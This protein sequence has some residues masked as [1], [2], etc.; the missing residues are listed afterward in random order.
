MRKIF[1]FLVVT[2]DGIGTGVR[3]W[4]LD[5]EFDDFS[6]AQLD[7]ADTLLF[8][9]VTYEGMAAYWPTAAVR[10]DSP[11]IADRLNSYPKLVVS[12]TLDRADWPAAEICPRPRGAGRVEESARKGHRA[13][14]QLGT[15]RQLCAVGASG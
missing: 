8:G 5:P 11:A 6:V 2:M 7:E 4:N 15:D 14:R 13:S 12:R 9:R 10:Q 3:L 1:A